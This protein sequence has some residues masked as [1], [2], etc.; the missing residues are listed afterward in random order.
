V[1]TEAI[2]GSVSVRYRDAKT[3]V[4]VREAYTDHTI[5]WARVLSANGDKAEARAWVADARAAN[6][7]IGRVM[8][9]SK[10]LAP[11]QERLAWLA[12]ELAYEKPRV[13][14]VRKPAKETIEIVRG[15]APNSGGKAGRSAKRRRISWTM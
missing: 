10:D 14:R 6:V 15:D 9:V 3:L 12:E 13:K 11:A 8:R 1:T 5:S 2:E 4:R 7:E